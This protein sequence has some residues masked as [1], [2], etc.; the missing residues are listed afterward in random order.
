LELLLAIPLFRNGQI[1]E[2]E[3]EFSFE[4]LC[5]NKQQFSK[6]QMEIL[7]ESE[8]TVEARMKGYG[9]DDVKLWAESG[10]TV[11]DY[12]RFFAKK[13]EAIAASL[14]VEHKQ[15]IEG[16]WTYITAIEKG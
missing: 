10:V 8:R 13:W 7:N 2:R 15:R 14:G 3:S 1:D 5:R 16:D 12:R 6:F 9:D 11:D 4:W